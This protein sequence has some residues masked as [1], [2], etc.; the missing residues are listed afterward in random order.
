MYIPD[1]L[2]VVSVSSE[3]SRESMLLK[4]DLS[5]TNKGLESEGS[6]SLLNLL[7]K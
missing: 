6:S 1:C 4:Q 7:E 2:S 3:A 5:E